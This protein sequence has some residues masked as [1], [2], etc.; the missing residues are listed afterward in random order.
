MSNNLNSENNINNNSNTNFTNPYPNFNESLNENAK[1]N[2]DIQPLNIQNNNPYNNINNNNKSNNSD[3]FNSLLNNKEKNKERTLNKIMEKAGYN[4]YTYRAIFFA[5]LY[6]FIQGFMLGYFSKITKPFQVY[7]ELSVGFV[8]MVSSLAFFGFF[9]GNIS[10]NFVLK[11]LSLKQLVISSSIII[12]IS[13]T[14]IGLVQ[15]VF[16]FCLFRF[17][18]SIFL[19]YYMG[20]ILAIFTEYLPNKFRGFLLNF[21]WIFSHLG[22]IYSLLIYDIYIPSLSYDPKRNDVPQNFFNPFFYFTLV[23]FLNTFLLIFYLKDSPRNLLLNNDEDNLGE[24]KY[25]LE[26]YLGEKLT[27]EEIKNIKKNIEETGE[28]KFSK[29]KNKNNSDT[30]VIDGIKQLFSRHYI[31][32]TIK[33]ISVFF[34]FSFSVNGVAVALPLIFKAIEL[35][36]DEKKVY[37]L[38]DLK[39]LIVFFSITSISCILGAVM[40]ELKF[41]GKK[42]SEIILITLSIIGTSISLL[43]LKEFYLIFSIASVFF[44][45]ASNLHISWTTEILPT[46]LRKVG[47]GFYYG[48]GRLGS[49]ISQFIFIPI[50]YFYVYLP[51]FI[52]IGACVIMII[53]IFLLPKNEIENL[54]DTLELG[55]VPI[56]ASLGNNSD[57]SK[58]NL[59]KKSEGNVSYIN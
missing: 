57:D 24:A 44:I 35:H 2:S 13:I 10:T 3:E 40:S 55:N 41:I 43:Y 46:K 23:L 21:I 47:F 37:C 48:I 59:G 38:C 11:F 5:V 33:M 51:I 36:F 20:T 52:Y 50:A 49:V 22:E 16:I 26:D 53:I 45:S 7:F 58:N 29:E 1:D 28:N 12:L 27:L 39:S 4:K 6:C 32:F 14:I 31:S 17:I 19:G 34:L 18:S 42:Y 15:N 30:F 54:D 9:L 56:S 25:I 8:S